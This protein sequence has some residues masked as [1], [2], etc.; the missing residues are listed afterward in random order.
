MNTLFKVI[1]IFSLI[2]SSAAFAGKHDHDHDHGHKHE[3]KHG[4][5]HKDEHGHKHKDEHKHEKREL[6]AHQHG[7][8]KL[9]IATEGKIVL[10]QLEAPGADIYGFET[11]PETQEQ[12]DTVAKANAKL[13]KPLSL[14]DLGSAANCKTE[15][16]SIE[17]HQDKDHNE[18]HAEY[19]I[20]CK[21]PK[22]IKSIGFKYFSV[23]T[24]AKELD[25]KVVGSKGQK[26]YEVEK[27]SPKLDLG[28]SL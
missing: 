2:I 4:H 25:V 22:K 21:S 15:N 6:G 16:A 14:F 27:D 11:T 3:E 19:A 1:A 26:S 23:F 18:V 28:G 20:H 8:G 12:K 5:K 13:K 10:I 24:N 17:A 9:N 7:H